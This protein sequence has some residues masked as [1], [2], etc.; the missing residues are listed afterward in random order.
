MGIFNFKLPLLILT[1]AC[2]AGCASGVQRAE[3]TSKREA[4]FAKGGKLATEVTISLTKEAQAMVPDNLKF[5][6]DKL[7][8]TVKRALDAKNLLSKTADPA[9]PR[10]EILVTEIR[11]RSNVAAVLF[12]FMAGSDIIVGDVIARDPSGKELQ[13]FTV[14]AS[15][16]LGGLGGGQDDAR[17]GWL[18]ET[19][20]K[21]TIEELNGEK[22]D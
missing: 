20:A 21:H 6:Q 7:L 22:A 2:L 9:L 15:Y 16:A 1:V 3:D 14:S 11:V 5:D 18:Y 10:I 12:G 17:M 4:Y 13:R 8:A 19:F